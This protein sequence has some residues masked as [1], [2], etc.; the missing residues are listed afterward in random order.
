MKKLLLLFAVGALYSP[1]ETLA[2]TVT[3]NGKDYEIETLLDYDLGP[4]VRYTRLRLPAYPL[5]VNMLR[6][7]VGNEYNSIET[8]QGQDLLYK[9]ES[10]VTAAKRQS[11]ETH[12]ALAGANANFWCVSGQPPYSDQLIGVTYNGNVKNGKIITELNMYNDQ[13]NGG[14]KHTGVLAVT[15]DKKVFS[16]NG[17]TW[18]G[19]IT[20]DAIGETPIISVNKLVR[21]EELS[22]YN[23]YYGTSRTFR[24][25]DQYAK[26]NNVQSFRIVE[27]CATEVYLTLD[28]GQQ[29]S[30]GNDIVFTVKDVKEN[31][32][33]GTLGTY[34]L[35]VVGRG[36]KA[37][38]LKKLSVG[39]KLT[40][41]YGFYNT[42]GNLIKVKNLVG[43]NAQ[44]MVNGEMTTYATSETYNSQIY[45]RTG[46]GASADNKTLYIIVIDKST[47]PVYGASAGCSV[48]VMC[49]IAK[50]YGCNNMT[51]FDAGGSAEMLVGDK[52]INK[53]T[54]GTPRAVA[55]GMIA[56]SI[57]PVD[58]EIARLEFYDVNLQSPVYAKS[59]PRILAYNKYGALID[60]DFKNAT[61][62]CDAALG[63]CDGNEFTASGA[64]SVG[65]L[66]ATY[67]SVSVSKNMSVIS[68]ELSLRVKPLLI[69]ATRK[70]PIEVT[71]AVDG[72][73][74]VYDPADINWS[75]G[76]EGVV[77]IDESGVLSGV[78]EGTT[79]V[80]G[81]I[82]DF[83]DNT[84]VTV[85]I[86]K[87]PLMPLENSFVTDGW[88]IK[89]T[90]VASGAVLTPLDTD[91]GFTLDFV[92]NAT[93]SPVI[94]IAKDVHLYSLPDGFRVV[95]DP[96]TAKI[97]TVGLKL[98]N[99]VD[100]PVEIKKEVS[101]TSGQNNVI[102]FDMSE[103]GNNA[104]IAF[105]PV[106]F[107]MLNFYLESTKGSYSLKVP[108][109][110]SVY[111]NYTDGVENVVADT[112]L[113]D[114]D[115][116][117]VYYNLQGISVPAQRL[118]PG[119]YIRVQGAEKSKVFVK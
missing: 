9:T 105:F 93:R 92:V 111:N 87:A 41:Q 119:I 81:V 103:F 97:K 40:V 91:F 48:T 55:N 64:P 79:T 108:G 34:D 83:S 95:V 102:D 26:D 22:I 115:A 72:N 80:T 32:G 70:Y 61:L 89:R 27:N 12:K 94:G 85:E 54:E 28:E 68:A 3:T 84:E 75:V 10:L 107:K 82:G 76:A 8:T 24:C 67:N 21:D 99:A 13:W 73:T 16:R 50:V 44:V 42:K 63:T 51:N 30:C 78:A 86:A 38:L 2:E 25:V 77:N 18:A 96:G 49:D 56:Y 52:I 39:D 29:W 60:D 33:N 113:A 106:T 17:Y 118:T 11:T 98:E 14:Y 36:S 35:A 5:N 19:K 15:E 116:P 4:G 117:I 71:A 45:S 109:A 23:S 114:P 65:L 110:Y 1:F 74:Y 62:S 100:R 101:L 53:T 66:T 88:A 47:D 69:D 46:Y 57:A 90:S 20:A 37:E 59:A 104:D 112:G 7:D 31:A 6:I 43:G 58:N